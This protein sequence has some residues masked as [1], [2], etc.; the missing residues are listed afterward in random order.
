M[1]LP[2]AQGKGSG[3]KLVERFL[4]QLQSQGVPGVHLIVNKNNQNAIGFYRKVGCQEL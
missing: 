2:I 3:R 1:T 4:K